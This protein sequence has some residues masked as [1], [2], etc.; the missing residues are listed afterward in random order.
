MTEISFQDIFI[1]NHLK[2][3][4]QHPVTIIFSQIIYFSLGLV[5]NLPRLIRK[6]I[7]F[8]QLRMGRTKNVLVE[9]KNLLTVL[10]D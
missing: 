2:Q 4:C 5:F 6:R 1:F 7:I 9:A 3:S 10:F 8:F